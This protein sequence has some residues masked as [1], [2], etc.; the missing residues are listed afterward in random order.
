MT[1]KM[2]FHDS[3]KYFLHF[4]LFLEISAFS[5]AFGIEKSKNKTVSFLTFIYHLKIFILTGFFHQKA[6]I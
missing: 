6:N 3:K 2:Y 4:N 1:P 5:G